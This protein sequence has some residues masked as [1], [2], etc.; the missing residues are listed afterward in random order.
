MKSVIMTKLPGSSQTVVLT[1]RTKVSAKTILEHYSGKT[2]TETVRIVRTSLTLEFLQNSAWILQ[3]F[4][5]AM[6]SLTFSCWISLS[7]L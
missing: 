1:L 4:V 3:C 5:N 2:C 7:F 6:G